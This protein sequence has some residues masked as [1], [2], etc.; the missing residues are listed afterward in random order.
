[1]RQWGMARADQDFEAAQA[2]VRQMTAKS[3]NLSPSVHLPW[4]NVPTHDGIKS[5]NIYIYI[6]IYHSVLNEIIVNIGEKLVDQPFCIPQA[7]LVTNE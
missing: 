2:Y 3:P 7:G 4:T 1:M 6:Y 5:N